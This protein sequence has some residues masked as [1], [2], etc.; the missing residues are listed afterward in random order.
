MPQPLVRH[1]ALPRSEWR[2]GATA[3]GREGASGQVLSEQ[4]PW[5]VSGAEERPVWLAHHE[6]GVGA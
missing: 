6:Q 2:G 4:G 3:P 5:G 1:S